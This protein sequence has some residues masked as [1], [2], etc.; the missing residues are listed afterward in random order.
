M[1]EGG[2]LTAFWEL[3]R[4]VWAEGVFGVDVSRWIIALGIFLVFLV[5]RRLFSRIVMAWLN[6][7]AKRTKNE[8]DEKMIGALELPIRFVPIVLGVFFAADHLDLSGDSAVVADRLLRSL[9][10]FTIFWGLYRLVGPL[11]FL[12]EKLKDVLGAP[13]VDWL[14]RALKVALVFLGA[15]SV[16][17]VWG[18]DVGALLAGLGLFGVAVALGAQ[19]LFK[20]LIAGIL[21][22]AERR[23][24][25]GD[26]IRVDGVVEG[27]VQS[28]G[29]RSTLIKRFDMAPV[30]VPN[31]Q[32]SDGAVT[33]FSLMAHRRIYW[34][35][36]LEYRTTVAQLRQ[37]R[38]AIEAHILEGDEFLSPEEAATFVRVD[39]FSDSSI[40]ILIYCFTR[41]RGWGEWL[42]IKEA[43][44][45]RLKDI[46]EEAGAGFAFPSQSI[47]VETLPSDK[48]EAFAPPGTKEAAE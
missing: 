23:F 13:L 7:M 9:I 41:T 42:E 28:I 26:W 24:Q 48:P 36:G 11:A 10:A 29:F 39:R 22:L 38:D 43:F 15:A 44:A 46:V 45:Y 4:S 18:I 31:T 47:Y 5:L 14:V 40:D 37:I 1:S 32:L 30:Y 3:T 19:D 12:F 25:N 34:M 17:E 8:L 35:V 21:I 27:T 6:R 2:D 20:N 16:L 33:N